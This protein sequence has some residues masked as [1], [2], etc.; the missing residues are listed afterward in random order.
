VCQNVRVVPI[1]FID[2]D[3]ERGLRMARVE[4][5]DVKVTVARVLVLRARRFG[6]SRTRIMIGAA[7]ATAAFD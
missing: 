5:G 4:T 1:S 2:P 7:K 6:Q 3:A